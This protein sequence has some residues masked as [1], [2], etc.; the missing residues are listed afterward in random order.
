M[1]YIIKPWRVEI[2]L[3]K[4]IFLLEKPPHTL[5]LNEC[6]I[7]PRDYGIFRCKCHLLPFKSQIRLIA[8]I[9]L[10]NHLACFEIK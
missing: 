3:F 6:L 1:S 2:G 5:T 10:N 4:L 9:I 8:P 7:D